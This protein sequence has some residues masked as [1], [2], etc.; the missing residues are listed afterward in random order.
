MS[1]M[2]RIISLVLSLV[3]ALS[4]LPATA[5]AAA[6]PGEEKTETIEVRLTPEESTLTPEEQAD[7]YVQRLF[8]TEEETVSPL[9]I[10]TPEELS[11]L[12]ADAREVHDLLVPFVRRVAEKGGS[13]ILK[14]SGKAQILRYGDASWDK[15]K[16]YI[17][18]QVREAVHLLY[19]EIPEDLYWNENLGYVLQLYYRDNGSYYQATALEVRFEVDNYRGSGSYTVDTGRIGVAIQARNNA[20]EEARNIIRMNT[21]DPIMDRLRAMKDRICVLNTYNWDSIEPGYQ[22]KDDNQNLIAVFDYD[23]NTNVVCAGYAAAFQYLCELVFSHDALKCFYVTGDAGGPHAWNIVRI[24]DQSFMVDVTNCD[25]D[26]SSGP[27]ASD[28]YFMLWVGDG[29]AECITPGRVYRFNGHQYTYR[30]NVVRNYHRD[31]LTLTDHPRHSFDRWYSNDTQHWLQC[32]DCGEVFRREGHDFQWVTVQE[33]TPDQPGVRCQKCTV[34][35]YTRAGVEAPL[36]G[37]QVTASNVAETGKPYITWNAMG[38][39]VQYEVYRATSRDGT[40][41]R[42]YTTSGTH[43][44]NG[45]A[46]PDHTY[47]YKV[48]GISAAGVKGSFSAPV[49]RTCDLARPELTLHYRS[50]GRPLLTWDAVEGAEKYEIYAAENGGDYTYLTNVKGT[51]LNHTSAHIGS[52]YR[53]T[54]RAVGKK[55]SSASAPSLVRQEVTVREL[56]AVT[57]T[58][59]ASTGKPYLQWTTVS[60]AD[61]YEVWFTTTKGGTYQ[62]LHTTSGTRLTHSSAKPGQTYYY[63]VR[64]V[65]QD[66]TAGEV[67]LE[68]IRTCDLARPDVKLT[69][70]SG[71]P[72]LYWKAIPGAVKYD[73][74]CS[75]DGGSFRRLLA[76]KGTRLTHGS[77]RSGHTYRYKVRAIA[78]KSAA[79]SAWSYYDTITVK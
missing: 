34:C 39:A 45:S 8:A 28:D 59:K 40:Y 68:R 38:A 10:Y 14:I 42:L 53:Y 19:N 26:A 70:R 41:S 62:H 3:M 47:Y 5:L 27:A 17:S 43:L 13:S 49:S 64:A 20:V 32:V 16:K 48:R 52:V 37:P 78:S 12:S 60:G 22:G 54:V 2:K 72:Y 75:T 56:P 76:V 29:H 73:V 79:N 50:D 46:T 30:D 18:G 65:N 51:R 9:G 77:A 31:I 33:S 6:Q 58:N 23:P 74:Y 69:T 7:R 57:I 61:A 25:R 1:T 4:L 55:E 44:T 21:N 35:G 71:D 67:S 24:L 36:P 63:L 11:G 66:N 15:L